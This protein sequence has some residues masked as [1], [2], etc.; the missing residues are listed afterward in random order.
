M[1]LLNETELEQ[2]LAD[3]RYGIPGMDTSH[4]AAEIAIGVEEFITTENLQNLCSESP[5]LK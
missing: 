5:N 2:E 3:R 4:I 1:T